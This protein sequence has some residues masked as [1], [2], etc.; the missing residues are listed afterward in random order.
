MK[1]TRLGE[2]RKILPSAH[3]ALVSG[4]TTTAIFSFSTI[5][6]KKPDCETQERTA[7]TCVF[8]YTLDPHFAGLEECV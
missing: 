8:I 7:Y 3:K 6:M 4:E 5:F 1:Q 2:G